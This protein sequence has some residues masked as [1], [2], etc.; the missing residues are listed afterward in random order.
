MLRADLAAHKTRCTLAFMHAPRFTSGEHGSDPLLRDL[1]QVLYE[2]GVDVALAGHDHDYERFAPQNA[3][4][5]ADAERGIRSFVVGTGGKGLGRFL[6]SRA[7]NSEVDHNKSIGVL[8]LTLRS[9]D[10]SWRF[11]SVP[12]YPLADSGSAA[13]NE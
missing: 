4:G 8:T 13:C 1:W 6:R 3:S 9:E 12:G 7:A 5:R 11:V 2:G 10:Y